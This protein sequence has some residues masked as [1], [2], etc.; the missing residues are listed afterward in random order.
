MS[1]QDL[2][3]R[4]VALPVVSAVV[5]PTEHPESPKLTHEG[6]ERLWVT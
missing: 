3:Q 4:L 1:L 6:Y 2:L 5:A